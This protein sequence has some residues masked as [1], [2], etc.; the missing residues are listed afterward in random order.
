MLLTQ[1]A[2]A[3]SAADLWSAT[4]TSVSAAAYRGLRVRLTADVKT[5]QATVGAA[6]WLRLDDAAGT[7]KLCNMIDPVDRRLKGT[8]EFT[9]LSC[10]LDVPETTQSV[11]F[12]LILAGPGSAWV[13]TATLETVGS[14]VPETPHV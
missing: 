3:V 7:R 9:A 1:K 6:V 11:V 5:Q 12:G 10:V 2:G 8:N 14:D 4:G 13:G